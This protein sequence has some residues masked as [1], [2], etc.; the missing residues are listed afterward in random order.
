M[1][2][3]RNL[4]IRNNQKHKFEND[5]TDCATT[6]KV[7]TSFESQTNL[8]QDFSQFETQGSTQAFNM[9]NV[10]TRAF[11]KKDSQKLF[12]TQIANSLEVA[13]AEL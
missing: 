13:T 8:E 2:I 5:T 1:S 4:V 11:T 3:I 12:Y 9:I 7:E 10:K 6:V